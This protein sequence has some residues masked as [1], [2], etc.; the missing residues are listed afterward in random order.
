MNY[1]RIV[2]FENKPGNYE[3]ALWH[4]ANWKY[5]GVAL[6]G[7]DGLAGLLEVCREDGSKDAT[8]HSEKTDWRARFEVTVWS[9]EAHEHLKGMQFPVDGTI[10][11]ETDEVYEREK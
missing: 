2:R 3:D 1:P 5:W 8:N 10:T 4:Y 11:L 6:N 7:H 9:P